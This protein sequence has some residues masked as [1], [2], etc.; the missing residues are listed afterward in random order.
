MKA[1][2]ALSNVVD[3]KLNFYNIYEYYDNAECLKYMGQQYLDIF[4]NTSSFKDDL[5]TISTLHGYITM[6]Y[7]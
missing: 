7:N 1:V 3:K 2:D 5:N 4:K 6:F